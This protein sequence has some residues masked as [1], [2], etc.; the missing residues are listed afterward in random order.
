MKLSIVIRVLVAA[1][2]AVLLIW[3][4]LNFFTAGTVIGS[5]LFGA[6]I[7]ICVIWKPFCAVIKRLWGKLGGK[8]ALVIVGSFTAVC[9]ACCAIFTVNIFVFEEREIADPEAVIVLGCQVRGEIPSSM[10]ARRLDAALE[11][12]SEHP[13]AL[14]VVSGGQGSG[15]DISEAEAMRR[16]L[17]ERG[18][19][20]ERIIPEDRSV[21]TRENIAYSAELLKERGIS[22][23]VIVTNDFH[24]FRADIYARRNRL[25][26]GHHSGKT[27][28]RNLPNYIVREWA[29]LFDAFVRG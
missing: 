14:V 26:A 11:T 4:N 7:L 20:D 3:V 6:V 10:L 22:R 12:L 21:D 16:Y 17:A 18:V 23:V 9:A 8:I 27:P 5:V 28:L 1:I 15:E 2:A 29:A 24:Q 13:N 19:S 25:T